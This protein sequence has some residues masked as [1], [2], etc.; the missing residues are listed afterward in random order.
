MGLA[1]SQELGDFLLRYQEP[2]GYYTKNPDPAP[3]WKVR[4]FD[5]PFEMDFQNCFS[6]P[7]LPSGF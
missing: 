7:L 4:G 1:Y 2:K 6:P 3:K 5:P